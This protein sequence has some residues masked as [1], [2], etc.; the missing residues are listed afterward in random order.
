MC[1]NLVGSTDN[2]SL[3]RIFEPCISH[4][5][6]W[7]Y[8]ILPLKKC[9]STV[10]LLHSMSLMCLLGNIPPI[11]SIHPFL[12][13]LKAQ[14]RQMQRSGWHLLPTF[15]CDADLPRVPRPLFPLHVLRVQHV[16]CS[17]SFGQPKAFYKYSLFKI[18]NLPG[19]NTAPFKIICLGHRV[20]LIDLV[21]LYQ[22]S[23]VN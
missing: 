18:R 8:I 22:G 20:M 23:G 19:Q 14:L 12:S 21:V 17:C 13:C 4:D 10:C 6:L 9:L 11:P 7:H 3:S 15:G 16:G 2:V 5:L 1:E